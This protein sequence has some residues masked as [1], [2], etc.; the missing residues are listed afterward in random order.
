MLGELLAL[1]EGEQHQ[2]DAVVLMEDPAQGP[3]LRDGDLCFE[4][5]DDKGQWDSLLSSAPYPAFAALRRVERP[6]LPV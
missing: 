4:V 1:V 5:G 6:Y 2:A 3:V